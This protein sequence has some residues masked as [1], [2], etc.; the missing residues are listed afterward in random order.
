MQ[1]ERQYFFLPQIADT[2]VQV[3]AT[4]AFED[5]NAGIEHAVIT[6]HLKQ[7]QKEVLGK[8][9]IAGTRSNVVFS[10]QLGEVLDEF[11]RKVIDGSATELQLEAF[12]I[13]TAEESLRGLPHNP[14]AFRRRQDALQ[15]YASI[16]EDFRIA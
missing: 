2:I 15:E 1:K 4:H 12:D 5:T 3:R 7:A 13:W 10:H 6:R 11:G 14:E 8:E 16:P 9:G